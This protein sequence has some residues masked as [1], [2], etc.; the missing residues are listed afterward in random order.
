MWK[1]ALCLLTVTVLGGAALLAPSSMPQP[2]ARAS[3]HATRIAS[4][5]VADIAA[6]LRDWSPT[7]DV[8]PGV[9]TARTLEDQPGGAYFLYVPRSTPSPRQILVAVHGISRNAREHI[10]VF[11]SHAEAYGVVLVAPLFDEESFRGYQRLV[12]PTPRAGVR[13]ADLSLRQILADVT[14]STG[15]AS[16]RFYLFG[17]S[18]GAQFAHRYAMAYPD[19]VERYVISAAG[20]YTPPDLSVRY[21]YG[22]KPR[23]KGGMPDLDINAF[24]RIPACV[25]VGANDTVRD[26]TLNQ[27]DRLDSRQGRT[28]VERAE[29]WVAAMT[30]AARWR[31]LATDFTLQ[32]LPDAG[33]DFT[34][35]AARGSIADAVF[36]CLFDRSPE[37]GGGA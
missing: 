4:A 37:G 27:A 17:H 11:Q 26:E 23:R 9:V 29:Y 34:E 32:V 12:V 36:E 14:R 13:R 22:M 8:A 2:I 33:H 20:W 19:S 7:P 21:P 16:E 15:V 10:E 1:L 6:V 24:L 18:G 5:A 31:D 35:M 3:S 25:L 28:R 30:A